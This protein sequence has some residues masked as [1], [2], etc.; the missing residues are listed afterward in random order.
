MSDDD[1]LRAIWDGYEVREDKDQTDY[2][3]RSRLSFLEIGSELKEGN[4]RM[5]AF[6]KRIKK[7]EDTVKVGKVGLK[8][9]WSVAK[10]I[11]VFTAEAIGLAALLFTTIRAAI[12]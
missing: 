11:A 9:G 1:K 10:Y 5:D 2:R 6:D 8:A 12:K 4:R 3:A 7:V